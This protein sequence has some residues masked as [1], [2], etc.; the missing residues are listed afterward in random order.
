[1]S[2]LGTF[3]FGGDDEAVSTVHLS[4]DHTLLTAHLNQ[5]LLSRKCI[6]LLG[7]III[8]FGGVLSVGI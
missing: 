8:S 1:M 4:I 2:Q 7:C 3:G 5:T 6:C